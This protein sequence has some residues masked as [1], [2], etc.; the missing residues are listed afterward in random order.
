MATIKQHLSNKKISARVIVLGLIVLGIIIWVLSTHYFTYSRDAFVYANI[1]DINSQVAGPIAEIDVK[2]NQ[3][4][5]AGQKLFQLD[6]RPYQ[7]AESQAQANLALAKV[8]YQKLATMIQSAQANYKQR[9]VDLAEAQ[10]LMNRYQY[11]TKT[12]SIEEIRFI[13]MRFKVSELQQALNVAGEALTIAQESFTTDE[14]TRD[15]AIL[16]QAT[17]NLNHATVYAPTDGY[18]TNLFSRIGDYVHKGQTLFAV[19]DTDHWWVITRYRETVL[20]RIKVGD[21]V[22]I[23][24]DMYPGRMF[25]GVVDSVGWGINRRQAS[26]SVVPT[27]LEYMEPTEYWIR[28]A[29]RFPVWITITD[30]DPKHPLRVGASARTL[31][32]N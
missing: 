5:K 13:D 18:V 30:L 1:I 25:T 7:Y 20:R 26:G 14:I 8:H 19:V 4:V 6:L 21:K 22:K 10:D 2:N 3:T 11:L 17:Y 9:Q 29:Q 24:I 28:I 27:G 16:D 12:G 31:V 15:Q 32:E 23:H